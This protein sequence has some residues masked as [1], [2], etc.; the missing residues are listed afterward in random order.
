MKFYFFV[1]VISVAPSVAIASDAEDAIVRLKE[2]REQ[3]EAEKRAND[4]KENTT[5][6]KEAQSEASK[7]KETYGL[8]SK[9]AGVGL[10]AWGTKE[11]VTGSKMVPQDT[12]KI[13]NGLFY[14]A[15]GVGAFILGNH[16]E[17]QAEE[18]RDNEN[19]LISPTPDPDTTSTPTPRALRPMVLN[20]PRGALSGVLDEFEETTGI[21]RS[22]LADSF[23]T[24]DED[25][26]RDRLSELMSSQTGIDSGKLRQGI[27]AA[28]GSL[29]SSG[30]S[31]KD[32][33]DKIGL[34]TGAEEGTVMASTSSGLSSGTS[35]SGFDSVFP[36]RSLASSEKPNKF[37]LD[38]FSKKVR[39]AL[40]AKG[41]G[42]KTL[43]S[44]VSSKYRSI[45]PLMLGLEKKS[46]SVK[47]S[48]LEEEEPR[49][50]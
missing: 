48:G 25:E 50:R 31:W 2:E 46:P 22:D 17:G 35:G 4:T 3:K 27:D 30:S 13:T 6:Q 18:G 24:E 23:L 33:A 20:D 41:H 21:D 28:S 15:G 36:D 12:E 16:L 38:R 8:I 42:A 19:E 37:K 34:D 49:V 1:F 45:T 10:I 40:Q 9:M 44:I 32:L 43:F 7:N 5:N 29:A 14:V 11:V 39:K 47:L 26:L